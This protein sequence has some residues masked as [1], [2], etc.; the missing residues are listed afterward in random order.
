MGQ[1][2]T[3]LLAAAAALAAM[4]QSSGPY[5]PGAVYVTHAATHRAPQSSDTG[6]APGSLCDINVEGLY[7]AGLVQDGDPVTPRFRAP[8]ATD[9]QDL[10][11][12]STRS[13]GG[14]VS[15]YTVLVP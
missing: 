11:V 12:V 7:F 1:V 2:R 3:M 9:A 5:V 6:L 10:T 14:H 8:G 4:A 15:Q 13:F